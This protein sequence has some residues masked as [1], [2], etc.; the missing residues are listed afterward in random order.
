MKRT[1]LEMLTSASERYK[2][3]EYVSD[4]TD[5]GWKTFTFSDVE[6][7]S[8]NLAISLI[9]L[10]INRFDRIAIIAEGRS[11]WI[12]SEYSILKAGAISVPLSVKLQPDELTFRII[13]SEAKCIFI[14]KNCVPKALAMAESLKDQD[15]NI[16]FLDND[17][18]SVDALAKVFK[19][20]YLYNELINPSSDIIE[21]NKSTLQHIIDKIDENDTV[22]ISYTSGTTGNPKGIMLSHLNYWANT[23]DSVRDFKLKYYMKLYVILPLDHTFAHTVGFYVATLCGIHLYFV[24]ARGGAMNQLKNIPINFKECS[25]DFVLSV[26][27]L[28]GNFMRKIQDTIDARGGFA[29]CLFNAGIRHG[30][31]LAGNG[32]N[33]PNIFKRIYHYPVYKLADLLIFKKVRKIF[34]NNFKF[35]VGG[36]AALDL[37]QQQFFNALGA[38]VFQGYGL[39]ESAP[40]ISVN[41]P[42]LYKFGTSGKVLSSINCKIM[43]QDGNEIKEVGKK[44][45]I[46]ISGLNVMKG[47]FKNDNATKEAI[48]NGR[49][50]TGDMGYLDKDGFLYVTGREKALLISADGEKYS[51]E[52]LEEAILNCGHFINQVVLYNDHCKYTTALVTLNTKRVKDYINQNKITEP[53]KLLETIKDS[54]FAFTKD[55]EYKSKFPRQWIPSVF[56]ILPE[57][58]SEQNHMVNSTMKIVRFKVIQTYSEELKSMYTHEGKTDCKENIEVLANLF[59]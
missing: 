47:Y 35:F 17:S 14:S 59:K 29:K 30:V 34:G 1:V 22:T 12:I 58:F 33:K 15:V 38:P 4:K 20:V 40:I 21:K 52:G 49:L 45:I 44:G 31:K 43:D 57:A 39:T 53:Q 42:S 32:Y 23:Q 41:C 36:G 24:D 54:F 46:T 51:P 3:L 56:R 48:V 28:T 8:S 5:T 25:P 10:G 18:D 55:S 50:N 11:A 7:L 6:N 9:N 37:K 19:N 27:A 16:I 13:H 2:D 26:P